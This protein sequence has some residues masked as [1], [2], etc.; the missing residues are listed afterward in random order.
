MLTLEYLF[1]SINP[2]PAGSPVED[3]NPVSE[4]MIANALKFLTEA[5]NSHPAMSI[6]QS[7]VTHTGQ[8]GLPLTKPI[9]KDKFGASLSPVELS[10]SPLNESNE[11]SDEVVQA[12]SDLDLKTVP[13]VDENQSIQMQGTL[14]NYSQAGKSPC[15]RFNVSIQASTLNIQRSLPISTKVPNIVFHC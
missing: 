11:T 9:C 14:D 8:T 12:S 6:Q 15:H 13:T 4:L 2:P 5:A 7:V 1:Y 3:I 10:T